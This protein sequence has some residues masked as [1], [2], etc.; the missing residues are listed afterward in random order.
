[1]PAEIFIRSKRRFEIQ[2]K[3]VSGM[4]RTTCSELLRGRGLYGTIGQ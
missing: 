3:K 2:L 4:Q 1:M